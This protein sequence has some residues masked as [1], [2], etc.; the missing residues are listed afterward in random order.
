MAHDHSPQFL[1]IA[2]DARSRITEISKEAL[3]EKQK[4]GEPLHL[5]DVREDHEFASGHLPNAEHLGKGIIE[6]DIEKRFPDFNAPLVL[7]CG[8][9]YR[10]AIAADHLQQM[11]YKNVLSLAG[12]FRGWSDAKLPVKYPTKLHAI[13]WHDLTVPDHEAIR[14]FYHQVVGW[15]PSEMQGDFVMSSPTSGDGVAGI[16]AARGANS[17]LPPAWLMY[18][19]IADVAAAAKK[20]VDLGGQVLDGPRNAGGSLFCC[21]RDPAG[22]V[23]ALYQAN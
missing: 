16:C 6:R 7:Y 12:G 11:G 23:C 10:S 1:K 9:G 18:I 5:I 20:C 22:A 2:E 8:G 13:M 14:D 19:V 21:I 4:N 17:K 15:Q 3:Q